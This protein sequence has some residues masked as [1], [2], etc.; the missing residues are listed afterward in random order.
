MSGVMVEKLIKVLMTVA[1][2]LSAVACKVEDSEKYR[3]NIAGEGY[4]VYR[5]T[6]NEVLSPVLLTLDI[7]LKVDQYAKADQYGRY[8]LEDKYFQ[9]YKVR[10]YED[11]CVL[12]PDY[13]KVIF[14]G[15]PVTGQGAVWSCTVDGVCADIVCTGENEWDVVVDISKT[16]LDGGLRT[17]EAMNMHVALDPDEEYLY[18]VKTDGVFSELENAGTSRNV[19]TEVTFSVPDSVKAVADPYYARGRFHFFDGSFDM[20]LDITGAM[21]R[22]EDIAVSLSPAMTGTVVGI[23]YMGETGYWTE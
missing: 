3:T 5:T 17:I 1:V 22:S 4:I 11:S 19:F 7:A 12:E 16:A 2:L 23:T 15:N 9:M 18:T 6:V 8:E 10:L 13:A 21:E 14:D 20:H